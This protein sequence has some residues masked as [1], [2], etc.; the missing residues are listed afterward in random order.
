[1]EEEEEEEEEEGTTLSNSQAC[2]TQPCKFNK[3][4]LVYSNI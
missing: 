2:V 3:R 4:T 1:M